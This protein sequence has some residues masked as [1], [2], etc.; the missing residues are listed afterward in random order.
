MRSLQVR[1]GSRSPRRWK[2][3]RNLRRRGGT[4]M[5]AA[6]VLLLMSV[7]FVL[8]RHITANAFDRLEAD[9]VAQDAQRVRIGLEGW[10]SLIRNY[11]ATNSIWDSAFD[12]VRRRDAADFAV[13]F[14]PGE[15][16]SVSGLD[17]V[18]G[19][20]PDGEL[21]AGGIVDSSGTRYESPPV[22][23]REPA[24][25]IRLFDPA[26]PAGKARCGAVLTGTMPY[27]FCGFA[28]HRSDGGAETSGGL[29]FL[30]ALGGDRL[31]ALESDVGMSLRLATD[32]ASAAAGTGLDSWLGRLT[33]ATAVTGP[34]RISLKI[35]VPTISG[36]PLLLEAMRG[37][38]IHGR[39]SVVAWQTMALIVVM[40][41]VLFG[42]V[43]AILRREVRQ[44]VGP[45]Y[46]AADV[47]IKSGDPAVRVSA[48]AAEN[49]SDLRGDIGALGAIIDEMLDTLAER[50]AHLHEVQ[51]QRESQLRSTYVQQ[52]LSGRY[53]RRQA[54]STI[55]ETAKVVIVELQSVIEQ[56]LAVKGAVGEI[57]ERVRATEAVTDRVSGHAREGDAAAAAVAESLVKV[58]GMA[59]LIGA[60]AD[61]TTMLALNATIE[62]ARAGESGRGF[63]VVANEVKNLASETTD[64]TGEIAATLAAL[65]QNVA[66][67]ADVIHR[68]TAGVGGIGTETA[69]LTAV[70]ATQRASMEALAD[71]VG[72]AVR[73][74]EVLSA[75]AYGLERRQHERVLVDGVVEI[76]TDGGAGQAALLDLS[77]GGFRC[78]LE[79]GQ[80]PAEGSQIGV[81]LPLGERRTTLH[82]VVVRLQTVSAG[83]EIAVEFVDEG[84]P[85]LDFLHDYV[86]ALLESDDI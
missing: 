1:Q 47:V 39:A 60:V 51:R 37:R 2:T 65:E 3:V 30:K 80:A 59:E 41:L 18:L 34:A 68:M 7:G 33:V 67:M 43:V 75:A 6:V 78:R 22:G 27:L 29:V 35:S 28:A 66:A 13:H 63:A 8:Q 86:T 55:A 21:L 36:P 57:D 32:A 85:G 9:Q 61:Q 26:A 84:Q 49:G 56:A 20:S 25:L 83:L 16:H 48:V 54:Q 73:R 10:A 11:G 74:I 5:A 46:R 70:A 42:A 15:V 64:S 45:L 14:R 69:Q 72:V 76:V 31:A 4:A 50:D 24:E 62:A 71:A 53:V 79:S 12:A 40:A 82:G 77:E 58:G 17:G 44:Q 81:T 23:L 19:L 38:P 52:R